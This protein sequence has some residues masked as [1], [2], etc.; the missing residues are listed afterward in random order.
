MGGGSARQPA[1]LIGIEDAFGLR[2]E[3]LGTTLRSATATRPSLP[4]RS[5]PGIGRR[6]LH[7]L[8]RVGGDRACVGF[9]GA[10]AAGAAAEHVTIASGRGRA[11]G[12]VPARR[13]DAQHVNESA[14]ARRREGHRVLPGRRRALLRH[15]ARDMGADVIKIEPP[16]GDAMRSGRR[17]PTA[18]AR[19][20]PRSTAT[21]DRSRSTSRTR[22]ASRPPAPLVLSADVLIEN[23]RP[24]VMERLGLGYDC[25]QDRASPRSSTARSPPSARRVRAAQEGGFDV[26][27]QAIERRHERH[28]RAG[29]RAGEVRRADRRL[30]RRPVRRVL[31]R[32]CARVARG[33]RHIDVPMLGAPSAS[34]RCR[35]ASTS[36]APGRNPGKLGSAHP[37]NAPYQAFRAT[38]DSSDRRRQQPPLGSRCAS[39]RVPE[40]VGDERFRTP[41]LRAQNQDALKDLLERSSPQR[42]PPLARDDSAPRACRARRSTAMPKPSPIRRSRDRRWCGRSRCHR[43]ARTRTVGCPV[44]MDGVPWRST[45]AI[46][47]RRC[48]RR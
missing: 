31:H 29:R 6:R 8:G 44:W 42:T 11:P 48:R 7:R 17:S 37:R 3:D 30:R 9:A 32:R 35:R 19:T 26:T 39:G 24:G 23:N 21:S 36:S 28:R 45:P 41:T 2:G 22:A 16:E 43:A 4:C 47:A 15:A 1:D 14:A 5:A 25:V 13:L 46:R 40:L 12:G 10:R 33:G 27:I 20:S 18:T 34:P 38:T